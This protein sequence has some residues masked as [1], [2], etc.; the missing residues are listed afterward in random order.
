M[1]RRASSAITASRP[2]RQA[3]SDRGVPG[4][5][6]FRRHGRP[7]AL[8]ATLTGGRGREPLIQASG[9]E[10]RHVTPC[11]PH[12]VGGCA[13]DPEWPDQ[14]RP[15]LPPPR[16]AQDALPRSANRWRS[17][18]ARRDRAFVVSPSPFVWRFGRAPAANPRVAACAALPAVLRSLTPEAGEGFE[19][20]RA[21]QIEIMGN[22]S[23]NQDPSGFSWQLQS[24]ELP[25]RPL[26]TG[27]SNIA[28]PRAPRL[29]P[30][31]FPKSHKTVPF[32]SSVLLCKALWRRISR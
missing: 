30:H 20:I 25:R 14:A 24:S 18:A 22:L 31:P 7:F 15:K 17:K 28:A 5:L 10:H 27:Y 12:F 11:A 3:R 19:K 16:C 26:F 23:G 1:S 32:A 29:R 2:G 4:R 9:S 21:T 6:N 8:T 13:R